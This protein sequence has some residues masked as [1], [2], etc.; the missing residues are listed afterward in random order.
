MAPIN[1]YTVQNDAAGAGWQLISNTYKNLRTPMEWQ[2]PKGHLVEMTYDEW[3]KTH[4]CAKCNEAHSHGI[5]R[6]DVPKKES[7]IYRVLALDA[8]TGTTGWSI[9]D[10]KKLV[11]YGTFN[12]S[13]IDDKTA[14]IHE[15]K[16]WLD[17]LLDIGDID[18]VG[19][20]GIQLQKNVAM[21]QTL[22][23]LQGVILELLYERDMRYE[24]AGSS[25]WRSFL[26]VNNHDQR[27]NAKAKAQTWVLINYHLKCTQDEADAIAMGKYFSSSLKEKKK[28]VWGED[29]L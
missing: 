23:N 13:I 27:E 16:E 6:N 14:R 9:Y 26:G 17:N 19:I 4:S 11:A 7:G 2:C 20:E 18:A 15:V 5:L 21:F 25:V 10:N 24:V 22:A 28:I 12:T 3:R 1:L 8:A 29:I